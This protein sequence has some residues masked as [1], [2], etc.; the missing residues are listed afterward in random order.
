MEKLELMGLLLHEDPVVYETDGMPDME[1]IA[2]GEIATRALNSFETASLE[3]LRNGESL[4][5]ENEGEYLRMV[6]VLRAIDQC[7]ECHQSK[8]GD[9][10][11]AFS[12]E[13]RLDVKTP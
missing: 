1:S 6:G 12:Y 4:V 5:I 10:L 13:F 8:P 9:L 7:T 2:K 11:G 3:K